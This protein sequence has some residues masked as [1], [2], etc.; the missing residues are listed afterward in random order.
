MGVL[1]LGSAVPSVDVLTVP[2]YK[3]IALRV[4]KG[5]L[6]QVVNTYGEQ[7]RRDFFAKSPAHALSHAGLRCV[8]VQHSCAPRISRGIVEGSKAEVTKK[9]KA[10]L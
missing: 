9:S 3:G 1:A 10:P 6:L 7:A 2:A 4:S 8:G 5:Q